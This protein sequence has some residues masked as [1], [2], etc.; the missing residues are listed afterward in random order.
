MTEV[1][2]CEQL[3]HNRRMK[4]KQPGVGPATFRL[5]VRHCDHYTAML[6][7]NDFLQDDNDG[8]DR[9]RG[10]ASTLGLRSK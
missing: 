8:A 3:S 5:Q 2:V 10:I 6:W 4:L 1:H 7:K 9:D